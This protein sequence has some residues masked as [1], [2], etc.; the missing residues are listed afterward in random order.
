MNINGLDGALRV[1]KRS[2]RTGLSLIKSKVLPRKAVSEFYVDG[3]RVRMR[4]PSVLPQ[5]SEIFAGDAYLAPRVANI[6]KILD[7]GANVGLASL[8]MERGHPNAHIECVE[9]DPELACILRSNISRN[10][11]G[12]IRVHEFA[13]WIKD[14]QLE[15]E[16]NGLGGGR[17]RDRGL[18]LVDGVDILSW[19]EA[20]GPFD[21]IKVDIEGA[22]RRVIKHALSEFRKAAVILI[23]YHFESGEPQDLASLLEF[24]Q[25]EGYR[26]FFR[27]DGP[28][29]SPGSDLMAR[30]FESQVFIS[31]YREN[32]I[33]D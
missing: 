15:F 33:Y 26:Y 29:Y 28:K 19:M 16:A 3:F 8:M 5:V 4:P 17:L 20:N 13:A 7:L 30:P 9:C 21:L 14:T 10:S 32:T 22:E 27:N 1:L 31:A 6:K 23:E 25:S 2:P 12:R 11:A 18:A 24:L